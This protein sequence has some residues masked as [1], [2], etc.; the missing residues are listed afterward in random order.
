MK[1]A[2][3]LPNSMST[4]GKIARTMPAARKKTHNNIAHLSGLLFI[5]GGVAPRKTHK[6]KRSQA[7]MFKM[8][9]SSAL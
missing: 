2:L 1:S 4:S 5:G 7:I 3:A 6:G 9:Y 8:A